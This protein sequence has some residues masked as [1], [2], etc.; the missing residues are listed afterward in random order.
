MS[1]GEAVQNATQP[2]TLVVQYDKNVRIQA[3]DTLCLIAGQAGIK[4][5]LRATRP[6]PFSSA[7]FRHP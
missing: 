5:A 4:D 3:V 7:P 2:L 1:L 6:R